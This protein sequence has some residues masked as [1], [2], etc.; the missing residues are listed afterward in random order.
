[1]QAENHPNANVVTR[2]VGAPEDLQ[3]DTVGGELRA[4]NTFLPAS[5]GSTR[6]VGAEELLDEISSS[7]IHAAADKL[8][9]LTLARGSPD[10]VSPVIIRIA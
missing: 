8:I 2:A 4:G 3:V 6:V 7:D 9:E 1:M 5:D 10:N